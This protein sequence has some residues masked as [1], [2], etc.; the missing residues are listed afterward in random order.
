MVAI[1]EMKL[2]DLVGNSNIKNVK[3][4]NFYLFYMIFFGGGGE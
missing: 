1:K 3:K 4:Y 2:T